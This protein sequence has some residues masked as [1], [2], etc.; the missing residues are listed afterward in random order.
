MTLLYMQLHSKCNILEQQSNVNCGEEN[1]ESKGE[2]KERLQFLFFIFFRC[3]Q[4]F[5]LQPFY[6]C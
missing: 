6:T 5:S 1:L 2:R 4:I 3:V